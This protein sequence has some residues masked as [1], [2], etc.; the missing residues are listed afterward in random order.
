MTRLATEGYE[1]KKRSTCKLTPSS[2]LLHK[3][4]LVS[5]IQLQKGHSVKNECRFGVF[6]CC[7]Y[8]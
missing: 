5:E 6:F 7:F 8:S 1:K 2:A 4:A 3:R